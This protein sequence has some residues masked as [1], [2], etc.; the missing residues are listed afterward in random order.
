MQ[1][2]NT[3]IVVANSSEAKIYKLVQFP[4]IEELDAL[5]HPKSRLQN[6]DIVESKGGTNFDSVGG[7]RHSYEPKTDPQHAEN[8]KFAK[9]ISSYLADAHEKGAFSRLYIMASPAFLG[10]LR[11][12]LN[13]KTQQ[14]IVHELAK[15][16]VVHK[17]ADIERH[18]SEIQ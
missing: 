5:I 9:I 2:K 16:I 13:P 8:E 17:K 10:L 4:K 11:K 7:G 12:Q 6:H 14:T 15:D 3:W 1:S 18:L